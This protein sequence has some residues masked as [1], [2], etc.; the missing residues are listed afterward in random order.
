M[1]TFSFLESAGRSS[2][3]NEIIIPEGWNGV[4]YNDDCNDPDDEYVRESSLP[5]PGQIVMVYLDDRASDLYLKLYKERQ[6]SSL[7][8]PY[9]P[10]RFV[11]CKYIG[12]DNTIPIWY[13]LSAAFNVDKYVHRNAQV[14][15]A[16][17]EPVVAWHPIELPKIPV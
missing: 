6:A 10:K 7:N 17:T 15:F 9:E 5:E 14:M 8:Q 3:D 4:L 11:V 2:E 13:V 16:L 12:I 1:K